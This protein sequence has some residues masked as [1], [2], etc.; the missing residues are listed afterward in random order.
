MKKRNIMF[1]SPHHDDIAFSIGGMI[2]ISYATNANYYLIN[3]FNK[4]CYCLP[5]FK[6]KDI[7]KQRNV[8]DNQFAKQFGLNKLNLNLP[9]SSAIGHTAHSETIC[10]PSDTRRFIL[11]QKLNRI[12][13]YIRP[14]KLFCPL[15]IGG[16]IDHRMVKE[17][18]LEIFSDS[19]RNLIFYED[20]PYAYNYDANSIENIIQKTTSLQLHAQYINITSIWHI[21]AKGVLFYRSQVDK[22]VIGKVQG[23]AKRLGL[24]KRLFERIWLP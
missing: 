1:L 23:Y 6:T 10:V 12:F 2:S 20:L 14:N 13:K 24:N 18:C 4:T 8:E 16:H 21:K 19:Y 11:T 3:I 22:E 5:T 15:S 7:N 9:D 17:V